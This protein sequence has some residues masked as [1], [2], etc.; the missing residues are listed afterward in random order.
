[1]CSIFFISLTRCAL[2]VVCEGEDDVSRHEMN[3]DLL[4]TNRFYP[5]IAPF[6]GRDMSQ[7]LDSLDEWHVKDR[8]QFG[9]NQS[10]RDRHTAYRSS[11]AGSKRERKIKLTRN[12]W[13]FTRVIR[14]K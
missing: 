7:N 2:H 11:S 8:L 5:T 3:V 4:T 6:Y 1:M 14:M 13:S 10:E 12:P 9:E